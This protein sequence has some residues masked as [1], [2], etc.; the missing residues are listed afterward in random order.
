MGNVVYEFLHDS[1]PWVVTVLHVGG[2]VAVTI[3]AVLRKRE[4]RA[5]IGWIGLAWL[6][7][8]IGA[9]LYL[10]LGINR[11]SRIGV[12]LGIQEAWQQQEAFLPT[13]D[14]EALR[15]EV[16]A[17]F[18]ALGS[19]NELGERLTERPL[20]LGNRVEPLLHGDA[21]YPAMLD[22]IEGAGKTVALASYIFD[23]D[24]AGDKF[25]H[26]LCRAAGRGVEVRV[27]IDGVGARYSKPTTM[28]ER[29]RE[30]GIPVAGFLQSKR[31][32]LLRYANLRNHRKIL[33]VDGQ[34]GFTGGTNIREGHWLGLDPEFPVACLHF[35][36]KGPV[37]ADLQRVFAIDWAFTT[38]ESLTDERWFPKH[39]R[40]GHV[41]A[42]GISEGPDE[43]LEKIAEAMMGALAVAQSHVFI[44]TPYFLPEEPLHRALTVT[45]M[46][47]VEIDIVL[48]GRNN[49]RVMDWAVA[50][51]LE[52]LLEKG[53]RV[54]RTPAPFDHTKLMIVDGIWS[55]IGSSNWDARSLRLN[56]E[57]NVE[58]YS[59]DLA[60]ALETIVRE[61]ISRAR[62]MTLEDLQNRPGWQKIRD[63]VAR[64]GQPY[65]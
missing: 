50:P 29:L 36:I 4:V 19:L 12:S 31:P 62:S 60:S 15:D 43:D 26:A 9:V 34:I 20:L 7:P 3:H 18:P 10:I 53:C 5:A 48:P 35:K 32:G 59:P 39:R 47:G 27:L 40:A 8:V 51:I 11:I 57:F 33:V 45:A 65:L 16:L 46:R 25:F 63:G 44:V 30:A 23:N 41:A 52:P 17:R 61:K 64:L 24:R 58:C 37:V 6:A 21:A 13:K 42:R 28:I 22:A 54:H 1:W 14:E 2:A 55:L 49:I 56:F 38:G